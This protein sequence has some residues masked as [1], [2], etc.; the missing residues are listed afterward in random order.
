MELTIDE[1]IELIRRHELPSSG[2]LW[3]FILPSHPPPPGT[4]ISTSA[5]FA[6]HKCPH[7]PLYI[8]HPKHTHIHTLPHKNTSD[9]KPSPP[10]QPPH[11]RINS[12]TP[13]AKPHHKRNFFLGFPSIASAAQLHYMDI[14]FICSACFG[15]LRSLCVRLMC[16]NAI[17]KI[18]HM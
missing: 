13:F 1:R 8:I 9:T 11:P 14:G 12:Q 4:H 7:D 18:I 10:P 15:V 5:P 3:N 17:S 6:C 16:P 2:Y